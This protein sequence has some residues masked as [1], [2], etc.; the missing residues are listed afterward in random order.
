VATMVQELALAAGSLGMAGGQAIDLGAVGMSLTREQLRV[1]HQLKTGAMLRVSARLGLLAGCSK[2]TN[3]RDVGP[4]SLWDGVKFSAE[5]FEQVQEALEIYSA[6][7]GLAFQVVDDILDV[8]AD[9]ATLGKTAGKDQ[10]QGKPTFVSLMGLGPAKQL[11]KDL[12]A[13]AKA[14][15]EPFGETARRLGQLADLIVLRKS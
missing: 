11:A 1:M 7:I 3:G 15:I 12:H 2:G 5:R 13:Q 8:E 4:F 14:A 10:E 9:S 6:R